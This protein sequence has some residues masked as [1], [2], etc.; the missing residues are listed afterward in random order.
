MKITKLLC[1]VGAVAGLAGCAAPA[2]TYYT[3]MPPAP[4]ETASS[5]GSAAFAVRVLPVA[6][7]DQ[8]DRPQ[9]VL[10]TPGSAQLTLLNGSLWASPLPEEIRQALSSE[11]SAR[12]GVLSIP[13]GPVPDK[14][15][16]WRIGVTVQRFELQ[17]GRHA[18]LDAGFRL[19][20][21]ESDASSMKLCRAQLKIPVAEGVA[22]IVEGQ[23]QAVQYL[24]AIIAARLSEK[25]LDVP[26]ERVII[27][28]CT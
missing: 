18:L 25:A 13:G 21:K 9:I 22:P 5:A 24:A 4:A 12:L 28:E 27:N 2:S 6:V 26:A 7:P 23:R 19:E 11:L 14:L 8:V 15:A 20:R 10:G 17:Y 3:L 16:L 1:I